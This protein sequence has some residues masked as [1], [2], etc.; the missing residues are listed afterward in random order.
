MLMTQ[1]KALLGRL[2]YPGSSSSSLGLPVN[3]CT[4]LRGVAFVL[5]ITKLAASV[6]FD[7]PRLTFSVPVSG[8]CG[9]FRANSCSS[10]GHT[11]H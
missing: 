6:E 1:R 2:L 3:L 8:P 11:N 7:E 9:F 4:I 10:P 5:I